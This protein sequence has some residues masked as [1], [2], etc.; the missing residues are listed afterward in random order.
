VTEI[1][2]GL[3]IGKFYPPHLGHHHLIRAM[4]AR[5]ARATVLVEAAGV[6]SVP[7]ADRV[8]WLTRV[9]ADTPNV[10][11]L[12]VRCDIPVDFGD[13][14]VWAAQVAVIRAALTGRPP[15]DAVF[16]SEGYGDELATRLGARHVPVDPGR[17][18]IPVSASAI[19]ADLAGS[20]ELLHPVV[21]A[22]L[23][24][25]VVFLGAESTGTTTLSSALAQRFRALGG[26]FARTG[27]VPEYGREYTD[28]KW[29][30]DGTPTLDDLVW[31]H[32]DFDHVATTQTARE[33]AAAEAGSP[34]LVCDTDSFATAVWERRYLGDSAR[35]GQ[36]WAH[37]LLPRRDIYLVTDHVG[38]PW[39]DDG[40]REGDLGV[41]AAMTDWFTAELT[42]AGHSWALLTGSAEQRITLATRIAD[43]LLTRRSTFADPLG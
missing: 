23:A 27:W 37:A 10:T 28:L 1:G 32:A 6:E 31:T 39:H 18:A 25:R 29:R 30:R 7:L 33:N 14:P 36:P 13:E 8:D 35:H 20:W 17:I 40:L 21:R 24:V 43:Q 15:V 2:H 11:V 42:A 3:A 19:R 4:A 12:G 26:V 38:V 9:H 34:L 41:R 22:G 16:S 5:C